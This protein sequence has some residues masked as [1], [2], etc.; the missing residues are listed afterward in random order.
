MEG[1]GR[2]QKAFGS[3]RELRYQLGLS[4]RLNF[5]SPQPSAMSH[6]LSAI[7]HQLSFFPVVVYLEIATS[8]SCRITGKRR[9]P[10]LSK[11]WLEYSRFPDVAVIVSVLHASGPSGKIYLFP[12]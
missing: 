1:K 2:W 11:S 9:F 8:R 3:F 10:P 5:F 12:R 6:E 4:N 7:S